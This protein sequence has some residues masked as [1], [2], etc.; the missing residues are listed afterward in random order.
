MTGVGGDTRIDL[1]IWLAPFPGELGHGKRRTWA[2]ACL[3][4]LPGSGGRKSL[5]PM[6]ARP[7]LSGRDQLQHFDPLADVPLHGPVTDRFEIQPGD[8]EFATVGH[9]GIVIHLPS[10]KAQSSPA[11]VGPWR[12]TPEG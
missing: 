12:E 1:N 6:A 5:R 11:S 7:G 4:G 9:I 8:I 3:R 10:E 2:P